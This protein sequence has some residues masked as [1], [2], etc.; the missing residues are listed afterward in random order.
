MI[1]VLGG[2]R[3]EGLVTALLAEKGVGAVV[4]RATDYSRAAVPAGMTVLT[5]RLDRAGLAA[6]VAERGLGLIID[7]T[8]PYA[9]E[10]SRNAMTLPVQYIRFERPPAPLPDDPRVELLADYDALARR[11]TGLTGKILWTAGVRHFGRLDG[12]P[13]ADIYVRCLPVSDSLDRCRAAG[14]PDAN[15]ITGYGPF[16]EADNARVYRDRGIKTL[17]TRESGAA[18]GF[19]EKVGPA[20]AL[21][22]TVLVVARPRLEYPRCVS[23]VAELGA[24][25]DGE[26]A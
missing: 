4:C 6:L 20:L 12:I 11:V 22:L 14:I 26:L 19:P 5:G 16:S 8:H 17:V 21:G 1:L 15:V 3:E 23:S 25:L 9:V 2:T 7:A 10:I 18:G 13:R 24:V